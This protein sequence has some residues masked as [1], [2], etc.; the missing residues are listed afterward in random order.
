MST[1]VIRTPETSPAYSDL[2]KT[3]TERD[4]GHGSKREEVEDEDENGEDRARS[5]ETVREGQPHLYLRTP[6]QQTRSRSWSSARS[7]NSY[8]DGYTH[9]TGDEEEAQSRGQDKRVADGDDPEKQFE[10]K[11]D[12]DDVMN[13]KNK[14]TPRKWLVVVI[15]AFSSLCVT[16]ASALYTSTYQQLEPEFGVSREVATVGLTTFVCGLGLGPMFLSPLSEFY[17]R[18]II[19][20]CAFGMYFVWLIPCAVAQNIQTMLIV[21]FFD[22]LAGSAF[23]SVAGGTV[24]DM[25]TKDKLSAPMVVYTASPFVG[26]QVGPV[27]GGFINQFADWRWSFWVLLIWAGVMWTLIFFFVPETYAPVLLRR[28]AVLLRNETGD[29][30]WQAPIER[31]Q[32][33]VAKTVLWSCIR[34]SQLLFF[35]QMCLNLCLLSAIL[36]G[37]I[38][39]FFGAF[40]LIF[41]NNHGFNQWQTGLTFLG[42]FVGMV[43]GVN[44]DPL[45]RRNYTRL[46]SNNGGVSEPEYRLPP[47]ILGAMIVPISL[48]GFAWTTY[49]WV[50]WIAPIIFSGLFGL[51][52]IFCFSGIFVSAASSLTRWQQDATPVPELTLQ[53][54]TFLV[55][56]Y[57][58]YAASALAANSFAR[59]S[60]AAAFPLFGVQMYNTL[61]YQWASSLLAFIALAMTPFPILF[62]QYGK[63]LRGNSRFAQA[64]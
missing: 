26:P 29:D 48:F 4:H 46:V 23:L 9:F 13:P 7:H 12:E 31:L 44:C 35:E 22:G 2:E 32:R 18:R 60:F 15:I 27:V 10:V 57:P 30:R 40:A 21:R 39:L 28:K 1:P 16:C 11:F 54:K 41:E 34:P 51:G 50:H 20:L 14:S 58:L 25:F 53:R 5:M 45:W 3:E 8:T 42:I 17:G 37:I 36:L 55:E 61:G 59:S 19:Y 63:R 52:N 43:I 24:G 64:S 38:Y 56:C 49:P 33:S 47:T 62:F 6:V